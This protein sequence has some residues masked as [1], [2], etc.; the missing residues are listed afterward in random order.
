MAFTG[1]LLLVN[2][3]VI[4]VVS[5]KALIRKCYLIR[6][7]KQRLEEWKMLESRRAARRAYYL[8]AAA[9]QKQQ[10]LSSIE[11]VSRGNSSVELSGSASSSQNASQSSSSLQLESIGDEDPQALINEEMERRGFQAIGG[12]V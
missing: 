1:L 2:M 8:E 11:D 12:N 4:I 7:K 6:L 10:S 9:L 3:A 5:I